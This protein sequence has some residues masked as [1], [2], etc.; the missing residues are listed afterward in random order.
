MSDDK[1]QQD[2]KQM[3]DSTVQF[4]LEK[5]QENQEKIVTA[6]QEINLTLARQEESL[7]LHIYRTGLAEESIKMLR[8]EAEK[9][10]LQ[11]QKQL[12]P[13]KEDITLVKGAFKTFKVIG[14][15]IAFIGAAVGSVIG[16][17]RLLK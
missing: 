1:E 14:S 8:T 3:P 4:I 11:V 13:I 5:L 15:V 17:L 16:I 9:R 10:E 6:I 7:R 12:V 2:Q